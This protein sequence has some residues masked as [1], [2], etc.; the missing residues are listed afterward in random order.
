M[1]RGRRYSC[2]HNT[3]FANGVLRLFSEGFWPVPSIGHGSIIRNTGRCPF[4]APAIFPDYGPDF[5]IEKS[6]QAGR[7][8][9]TLPPPTYRTAAVGQSAE[10]MAPACVME[11]TEPVAYRKPVTGRLIA[12][13]PL[14]CLP[15]RSRQRAE[16]QRPQAAFPTGHHQSLHV[17]F[18][19]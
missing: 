17:N 14:A 3:L 15:K 18:Q 16:H 6:E 1:C 2:L 13:L 5:A 11:T 10:T 7:L 19:R 4:R 8:I 12:T 9:E